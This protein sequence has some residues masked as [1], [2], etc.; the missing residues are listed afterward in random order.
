VQGEA[1]SADVE[2]VESYIE[3]LVEIIDEE[4]TSNIF[5]M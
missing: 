2:A 5:S 3:G 4:A 1:L